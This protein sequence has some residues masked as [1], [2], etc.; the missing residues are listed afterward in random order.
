MKKS[1]QRLD[2]FEDFEEKT[3]P[4]LRDKLQNFGGKKMIHCRMT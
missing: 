4:F 2:N 3:G 1:E